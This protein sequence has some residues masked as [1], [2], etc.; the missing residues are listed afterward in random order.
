MEVGSVLT[1]QRQCS[2]VTKEEEGSQASD[3]D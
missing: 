3:S 2:L 1:I